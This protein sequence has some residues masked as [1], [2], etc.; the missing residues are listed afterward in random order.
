MRCRRSASTAAGSALGSSFRLFN[1]DEPINQATL[2]LYGAG[3]VVVFAAGNSTTEMSLN[4]Y[5]AAP[6]VI[7]VGNGTLSRQRNTS[8]SGGIQFD[9]SFLTLLPAT[10]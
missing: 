6:W 4:P 1:P 8:S 2:Q 7:S 3:I 9:D 5:S 10:D